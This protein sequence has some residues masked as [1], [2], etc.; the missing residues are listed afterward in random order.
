MNVNIH[1]L[2]HYGLD[3]YYLLDQPDRLEKAVQAILQ[4]CYKAFGTG[5]EGGQTVP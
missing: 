2:I 3:L 1:Q 4:A 5:E